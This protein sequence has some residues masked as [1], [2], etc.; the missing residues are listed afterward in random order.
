MVQEWFNG[1]PTRCKVYCLC[2]RDV[3]EVYAFKVVYENINRHI[4]IHPQIKRSLRVDIYDHVDHLATLC[5]QRTCPNIILL[6]KYSSFA[7]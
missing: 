1:Y 4:I 5:S 6:R 3:Y 2:I 7:G